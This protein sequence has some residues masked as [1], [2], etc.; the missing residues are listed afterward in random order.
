VDPETGGCTLFHGPA[1][2]AFPSPLEQYLEP[3]ADLG[4]F[5]DGFCE[6]TLGLSRRGLAHLVTS[7]RRWVHG[8]FGL[9]T[10]EIWRRLFFLGESPE[11]V[12]EQLES[13]ERK[14]AASSV[15]A[16]RP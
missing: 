16:W 3:L 2:D 4:F 9:P 14:T 7:W 5:E 13:I 1:G 12:S 8:F 10:L 11:Q 15:A 6:R